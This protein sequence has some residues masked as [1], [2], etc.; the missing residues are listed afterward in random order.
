MTVVL[1]SILT[2]DRDTP[3]VRALV[4]DLCEVWPHLPEISEL[5]DRGDSYS[6]STGTARVIV[7]SVEEPFDFSASP[8]ST[9]TSPLWPDASVDLARH[10][11][12]IVVTVSGDL[13][14]VA[15]STLL[16]Q[17]TASLLRLDSECLGVLWHNAA[18]LIRSDRFLQMTQQVLPT[19]PPMRLWVS[20]R[21]RLDSDDVASGF[22]TGMQALGF[23]EIEVVHEPLTV[24]ALQHLME[25]LG[26]L[27]ITEAL[28]ISDGDIV[29][30]EGI[31][32]FESRFTASSFGH[33]NSVLRLCAQNH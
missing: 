11:R 23:P 15:L 5:S 31:G 28:N 22:T 29:E 17:V 7:A 24:A 4:A 3:D 8:L 32:C 14:G 6:F 33:A 30:L 20:Y 1:S 12:R 21:L 2:P 19:G 16:T 18:L 10:E 9:D 25:Y 27:Q 13:D 26:Q